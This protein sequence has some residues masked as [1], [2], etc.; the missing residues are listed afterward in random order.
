MSWFGIHAA[1]YA[2]LL[3]LVPPLVLFYFLKLRRPRQAV[4]S[5]FLWRQ[6][7]DDQRVN[8]PFQR[9]KRNLL[10]LLQL[11]LLLLVIL[12]AMQPFWRGRPSRLERLPILI[13]CSASMAALD[14]AGGRSRLE[15]AK[16]RV[17]QLID[18]KLRDQEFCII[19]FSDSARRLTGFTSNARELHAALGRIAVQ[20]VS[21]DID[22]ALR[23]AEAL[24]RTAAFEEV[25]LFSDGNFPPRADAQL[26]FQLDY[27]RLPAA[28]PNVGIAAFNATRTSEGDWAV[29]LSIEGSPDSQAAGRLEVSHAD[30]I[31]ARERVAVTDGEAE[32]ITFTVP[33]G[34]PLVL[35]ATLRPVGF[36]SLASDN[37]AW[38]ELPASRS[39][40]AYV[41]PSLGSYRH[42]LEALPTVRLF[43]QE[44]S[45]AAEP[46]Y[47]LVITDR[48][49][50]LTVDAPTRLCVGIVPADL[51]DLVSVSREGTTVVDWRRNAPLFRHV[52]LA[53]VLFTDQPRSK[54]DVRAIDYETRGY[55][56]LAEGETGP[57]VLEK[58]RG[59]DLTYWM[60]FHSDRS[61]LPYRIGFPILVANL[62]QEAME[63]A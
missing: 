43:P 29:F 44:G 49:A 24:T 32:R 16:A 53:E 33:G 63:R 31:V 2:W 1:S 58:R 36:D 22:D 17:A 14:E 54:P 25:L 48:E 12:A 9:F 51:R 35:E 23:M 59:N 6:V 55:D 27:Q 28:G 61:T 8:S 5:L 38:L 15:A 40:W 37:V 50:D 47:D 4:P 21:S 57:L 62:V 19:A 45:A 56:L 18:E 13:D 7:L 30:K 42:A 11:L 20:D 39:L 3:L 34:E 52:E 60:L 10:L 46:S 41:P 26:A